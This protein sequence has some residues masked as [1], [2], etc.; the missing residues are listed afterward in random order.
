MLG[1]IE[2]DIDEK[3]GQAKTKVDKFRRYLTTHISKA[4]IGAIWMTIN[5]ILFVEHFIRMFSLF[6]YSFNVN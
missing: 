2:V 4:I 3:S 5:V 6:L 1:T